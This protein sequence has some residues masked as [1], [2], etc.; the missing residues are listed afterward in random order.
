VK[1]FYRGIGRR[2]DRCNVNAS[3]LLAVLLSTSVGCARAQSS[4]APAPVD[5][6]SQPAPHWKNPKPLAGVPAGQALKWPSLAF[7]RDTLFVAANITPITVNGSEQM[8]RQPLVVLRV[9]GGSIGKPE[10]PFAFLFPRGVVA[11]DGKYH[12]F[13]GEPDSVPKPT[14]SSS[15]PPMAVRSVW[16][17][18]YAGSWSKPERVLNEFNVGWE[19]RGDVVAVDHSGRIHMAVTVLR[20]GAGF[21]LAYLRSSGAS[22]ERT[23]TPI[24]IGNS[25]SVLTWG[26]DSV[27][28]AYVGRSQDTSRPGARVRLVLSGN[29]GDSWSFPAQPPLSGRDPQVPM[30]A[31]SGDGVLYIMWRELGRTGG[32]SA[33]QAF[34][35]ASSAD[36]GVTWRDT[37]ALGEAGML[38]SFAPVPGLCSGSAVIVEATDGQ[39]VWVDQL[40]FGK[41]SSARRLF[42]SQLGNADAGVAVHGNKLVLVW[43][44][45]GKTHE[46]LTLWMAEAD[47]CP[48]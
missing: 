8:L 10:G 17:S 24:P 29:G 47:T 19:F 37:G 34:R 40:V 12:L 23:Y 31:R 15:W 42:P 6:D 44:S 46:T 13:W 21:A 22:W 43:S 4:S 33:G 16:H 41:S 38:G 9:P 25:G 32:S 5:Q 35:A 11:G 2:P 3:A 45:L 14:D 26:R 39:T 27:A 48:P 18:E 28:I 7:R 20:R 1:D 36:G 30:L